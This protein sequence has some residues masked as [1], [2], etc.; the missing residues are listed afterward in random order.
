MIQKTSITSS[1]ATTATLLFTTL[2]L[3]AFAANSVLG[4]LALTSEHIDPYSFT[5]IRLSSGAIMLWLV[6]KA[7]SR[8]SFSSHTKAQGSWLSA[9]M[10]FLYAC[11][12]SIA[13]L[14]LDTGIGA[15]IL[16]GAVQISMILYSF[17]TGSKLKKTEFLGIGLAF[18]GFLYLVLPNLTTPSLSGFILMSIAGIAWAGYTIRGKQCDDPLCDTTGNFIRTLPFTLLLLTAF[19]FTPS[20]PTLQG[21]LLAIASGALTSGLGYSLWYVA[22]RG[23]SATQAGVV[24]LLVPVIA[25]FGGAI[26]IAEPITLPFILA[27]MMILGGIFLVIL[28]SKKH[29]NDI[30]KK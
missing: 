2:A 19:L 29:H 18:S 11:T 10:L 27:S 23:L 25:A 6:L 12:F 21:I 14:S 30:N 5:I 13:Y 16:F 22:L 20:Q 4:R 28:Q 26:F 24:Q 9:F 8:L 7:R 17:F 1:K 15:L 3:I